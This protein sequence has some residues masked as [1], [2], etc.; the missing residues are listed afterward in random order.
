MIAAGFAR[1]GYKREAARLFD[2][3]F[4]ASAYI[5]LRRLPELFCG[6]PRQRS[7]GPT[8]YPVAC[9]PQAWAAATPLSLLQSCLGLGF[10]TARGSVV[11]DQPF[12]PAFLDDVALRR[13]S[14]AGASVDI[15]LHRRGSDVSVEV[16]DRRGRLGVDLS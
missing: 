11:L 16:T 5:D 15:A 9:S 6:F 8:F 14:L 7:Q 10:D 13:L 2:G 4:A 1:Y 3:L 12:L